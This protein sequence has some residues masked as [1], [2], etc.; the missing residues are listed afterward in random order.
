VEAEKTGGKGQRDGN[1]YNVINYCT[2]NWFTDG[3]SKQEAHYSSDNTKMGDGSNFSIHI[4]SVPFQA[5]FRMVKGLQE[6]IQ[7]QTYVTKYVSNK[8]NA[9]FVE[10]VRVAELFQKN[11]YSNS[12]LQ[13]KLCDKYRSYSI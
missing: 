1:K 13:S 12:N 6:E 11:S 10:R 7:N 9:T 5:I 2:Q 4:S 8:G 3:N